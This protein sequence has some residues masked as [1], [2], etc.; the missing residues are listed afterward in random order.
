MV[1]MDYLEKDGF[2]DPKE[3]RTTKKEKSK[4]KKYVVHNITTSW[5]TLSENG[6]GFRVKNIWKDLKIG[7]E[8]LI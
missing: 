5:V 6:N 1:N 3:G 4:K 8:I 7:D 2:E